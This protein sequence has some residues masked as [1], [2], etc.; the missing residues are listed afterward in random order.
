MATMFVLEKGKG[1][2]T[3]ASVFI[4]EFP[5]EDEFKLP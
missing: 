5:V 4:Q 3:Q 1:R 2:Y